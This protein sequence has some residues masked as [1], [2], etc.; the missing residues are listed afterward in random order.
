MSGTVRI[1]QA[2]T[3]GAVNL[4][5]DGFAAAVFKRDGNK[6]VCCDR[7]ARDPHHIVERKLFHDGGYYLGNGASLCEEHHMLAERTLVSVEELRRLAGIS[8]AVIPAHMDPGEQIDKWGNPILKDGRRIRGE[9]FH[10]EQVQKVLGDAGLLDGFVRYFKYPRTFHAPWSPGASADD[11][12]MKDVSIFAGRRVVVTKKKDGE[13]TTLYDDYIHARSIDGRSHPSRD[14]IK[15][16]HAMIRHDIPAGWRVC[17]ENVTA[18]HSIRYDNLESHF[19]GISVWDDTNVC[20]GW[21]ETLEWFDL[22]GIVPVETVYDGEFDEGLI[23]D[24]SRQVVA[25][26]EEG[27]VTRI[28]D[29]IP[30]REFGESVFKFVREGHVITD[31][32]WMHGSYEENVV[33][34]SAARPT[35]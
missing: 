30:Y 35:P 21:D 16:F 6:C 29:P 19:L 10:T 26:G 24:I 20:R 14:R 13:N 15:Q 1:V 2:G 4:G 17:M 33:A 8:V 12:I 5:R 34:S 25:E 23:R 3:G 27:T 32:H 28:A 22:L 11:K 7:V 31:T 18:V 9:M